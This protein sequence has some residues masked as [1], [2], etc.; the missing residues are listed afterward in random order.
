M[1]RFE[2]HRCGLRLPLGEQRDPTVEPRGRRDHLVEQE[3]PVAQRL[4]GIADH[5]DTPV[6][7]LPHR[8]R[9]MLEPLGR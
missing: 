3:H 1:R 6:A 4:L 5:L 7:E 8:V 2:V 9:V